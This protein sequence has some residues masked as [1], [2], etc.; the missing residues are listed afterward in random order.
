MVRC[1]ELGAIRPAKFLKQPHFLFQSLISKVMK[2][3]SVCSY[4]LERASHIRSMT[5]RETHH[6]LVLPWTKLAA[7]TANVTQTLRFVRKDPQAEQM[8][9]SLNGKTVTAILYEHVNST[10]ADRKPRQGDADEILKVCF[11]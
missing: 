2:A 6:L 4:K 1:L 10:D 11:V 5:C 8:D 7:A 3:E 9:R